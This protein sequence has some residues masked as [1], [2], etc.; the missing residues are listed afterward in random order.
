[1]TQFHINNIMNEEQL[2]WETY[3][4]AK[5][6]R[7]AILM[8]ASQ[9]FRSVKA[10]ARNVKAYRNGELSEEE[11]DDLLAEMQNH[12]IDISE[13]D[14]WIEDMISETIREN[15]GKLKAHGVEMRRA[16]EILEDVMDS[17]DP[18]AY[19]QQVKF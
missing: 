18:V 3:S 13:V 7:K 15:I 14:E 17:K 6:P 5:D 19:I 1:M 12:D 11:I 8:A 9:I 16:K 4:S 2:I 10:I